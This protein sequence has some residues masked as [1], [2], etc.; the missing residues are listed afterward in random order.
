MDFREKTSDSSTAQNENVIEWYSIF[1]GKVAN[2]DFTVIRGEG[3]EAYAQNRV[4]Q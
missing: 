2:S 1:G 4:R 3:E